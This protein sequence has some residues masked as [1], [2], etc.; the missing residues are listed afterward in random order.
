MTYPVPQPRLTPQGAP[1]SARAAYAADER[2]L[3]RRRAYSGSAAL[4]SFVYVLVGFA[5][6]PLI[7][8]LLWMLDVPTPVRDDVYVATRV[9]LFGLDPAVLAFGTA[10]HL[11]LVVAFAVTLTVACLTDCK[12]RAVVASLEAAQRRARQRRLEDEFYDD[13]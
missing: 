8:R 13:A 6:V 7:A 3:R 5:Q 11:A 9:V 12:Y 1:G 4:L 10:A 2:R